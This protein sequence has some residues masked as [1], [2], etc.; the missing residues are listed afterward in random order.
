MR[1]LASNLWVVEKPFKLLG[2][3]FG[4]RMTIIRLGDGALLLHSPVKMDPDT[5]AAVK[6]LGEVAY[7][8]KPNNFHGLYMEEW[9]RT[10]P[11]ARH[12]SAKI[13]AEANDTSSMEQLAADLPDEE[14]AVVEIM[15]APRVNEWALIHVASGTLVLT[16]VALNIGVGVSLWTKIFFTLN[17]A[18]Q[19]FGPSRVMRRLISDKVA[20]KES[21]DRIMQY[22]V[23]RI[24]VSHGDI[25]ESNAQEKLTAAFAD[26]T[27]QRAQSTLSRLKPVR[28]G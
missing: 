23:A 20:F 5:L 6:G 7:L 27:S 4:N 17:G 14:L 18:Y 10:F 15:G 8:V 1:E 9:R 25:V 2:A 28:C 16:D 11:C 19:R 22:D 21:M 13:D 24:I 26:I 3:E 12:F